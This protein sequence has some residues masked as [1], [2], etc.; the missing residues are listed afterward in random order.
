MGRKVGIKIKIW[1]HTSKG[2]ELIFTV[3]IQQK[4]MRERKRETKCWITKNFSF[5]SDN[6]PRLVL[7][8]QSILHTWTFSPCP[9]TKLAI[10]HPLTDSLVINCDY[11]TLFCL[12]QTHKHLLRSDSSFCE[13]RETVVVSTFHSIIRK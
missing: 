11:F 12:L 6:D 2:L 13:E 5:I 4:I 9:F 3:L 1:F 10:F 8:I 7:L